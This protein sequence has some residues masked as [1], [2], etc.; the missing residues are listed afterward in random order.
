MPVSMRSSQ[1][2]RAVADR[3]S[4]A[5]RVARTV[6]QGPYEGLGSAWGEFG[7]WLGVHGHRAGTALWECYVKGPESTSEPGT[8]RTELN[9]PL[10][11]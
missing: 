10:A 1:P 4:P 6:Y 5:A 7:S 3:S 11:D 2:C 8:W 9:R